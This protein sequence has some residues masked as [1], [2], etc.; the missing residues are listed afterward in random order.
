M[1][2]NEAS[3]PKS[4]WERGFV[5]YKT[6]GGRWGQGCGVCFATFHIAIW[7]KMNSAFKSMIY[8]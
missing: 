1:D 5:C 6:N 7:D 2:G 3:G 4:T 8:N